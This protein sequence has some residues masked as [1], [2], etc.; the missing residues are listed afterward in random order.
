MFMRN[1]GN[2]VGA[3]LLGAILNNRILAY[4]SQEKSDIV[5]E[6]TIES[7]NMLLNVEER[8]L[9]SEELKVILQNALS[10]ALNYVYIAVLVFACIS[11][12]FI[13]LIPKDVKN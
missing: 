8:V 13:Y 3:A 6:L 10:S 11:F 2:T 12:I 1:L 9:L 4:F 7:T 5:N